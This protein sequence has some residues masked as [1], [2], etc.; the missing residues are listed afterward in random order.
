MRAAPSPSASS[1][2]S[3]ASNAGSAELAD[4]AEEAAEQ[5]PSFFI[6]RCVR[7]HLAVEIGRVDQGRNSLD[8]QL[9]N[10]F[11][12][13]QDVLHH[14]YAL[15]LCAEMA[16]RL[17]HRRA[18]EALVPML[19]EVSRPSV[20]AP[21]CVFFGSAD[22]YR[23]LV[24]AALGE[25]RQA[26]RLL[27]QAAVADRAAG[28]RPCALRCDLDRARIV[29]AA[30]DAPAE[31][32]GEAAALLREVEREAARAGFHEDLDC[33]ANAPPRAHASVEATAP[34]ERAV[35]AGAAGAAPARRVLEP[36][37]GAAHDRARGREGGAVRRPAA[38]AARAGAER[39]GAGHGVGGVR[40]GGGRRVGRRSFSPRRA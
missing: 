40:R 38:G 6:L 25:W 23:G 8:A 18:A 12:D 26:G 2:P 19:S 39:D 27:R 16:E 36:A 14:D 28:L 9:A 10:G 13:A 35:G 34:S 3:C 37:L 4:E 11:E 15:A 33:S 31:V 7:A 22:R 24:A 17:G 32:R 21:S 1:T 20:V 5:L 29:R 30:P